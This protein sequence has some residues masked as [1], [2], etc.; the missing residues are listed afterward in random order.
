MSSLIVNVEADGP[1]PGRYSMLSFGAIV[2]E[3][4]LQ[5]TFYDRL[6]PISD[7]FVPAALAVSKLIARRLSGSRTPA[8]SCTSSR[9]GLTTT[10][11][12]N[13]CSSPTT[14][15]STGSHELVLPRL[16]RKE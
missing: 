7:D 3:P 12:A 4:G 8:M 10:P 1:I 11:K 9:P 5:Q 13:R 15:A 6:H 14:T 2:V 16:P